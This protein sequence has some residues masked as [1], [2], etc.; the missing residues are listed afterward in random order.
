MFRNLEEQELT[1]INQQVFLKSKGPRALTFSYF[2]RREVQ[3]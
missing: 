3:R 1:Q 2:K